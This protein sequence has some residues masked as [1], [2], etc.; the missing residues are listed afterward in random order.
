M[1]IRLKM[2]TC[3]LIPSALNHHGTYNDLV[4]QNVSVIYCT[5]FLSD[6]I[7]R[8]RV[9]SAENDTQW[10]SPSPKP[11][12]NRKKEEMLRRKLL[13]FIEVPETIKLSKAYQTKDENLKHKF[14]FPYFRKL[15]DKGKILR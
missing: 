1:I 2:I 4:Y 13:E 5:T 8:D 9:N 11:V 14:V 6:L 10:S 3:K 12:N 7:Q 15:E